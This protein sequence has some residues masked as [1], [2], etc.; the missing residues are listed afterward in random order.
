[1]V[2][3]GRTTNVATA[4]A[5][6]TRAEHVAV[7]VSTAEAPPVSLVITTATAN[8]AVAASNRLGAAGPDGTVRNP[9]A[10]ARAVPATDNVGLR[11]S[12]ATQHTA[13]APHAATIRWPAA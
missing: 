8:A 13:N 10:A 12:N 1:M 4:V 2:A 5:A 3:K 9:V 11:P 7:A 6:A